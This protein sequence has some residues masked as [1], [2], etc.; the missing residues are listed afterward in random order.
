MTA[1]EKIA[2]RKLSM[3]ELAEEL[4]NISKACK[5]MGYSRS[6]F[7]EIKRAFQL[8]GFEG[9]TDK[10]PIPKS[11]PNK[12]PLSVEKRIIALSKEHPAW[13][14]TRLS[15]ELA[16]ENIHI[17]SATVRN[18]LRRYGLGTKCQRLLK[19][20]QETYDKG[21]TLTIEQIK[22]IEKANPC[23][24]ERHVESY[25]PGYL[26]CQDTFFVGSL[27]GV[28]KIYLQVVVDSFSSY[29]FARL[30]TTHTAVASADMV[31]NWVTPFYEKYDL[32]VEHILT[33]RGS[34]FC[35]RKDAHPYELMLSLLNIEHRK[36]KVASP[37]TNGFVERF[38][39]TLLDEFFREAFRKKLYLSID[40][41]QKDLDVWLYYYNHERSHQGY[42]N[43]GKKPVETFEES[44]RLLLKS[45][46]KSKDMVTV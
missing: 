40:E 5:M 22:A 31:Y 13:G 21:M 46:G 33:D 43:M 14:K 29:G 18:I 19:L 32:K 11:F 41:L 10:M 1:K 26:L 6:Q 2:Q 36:T 45:R 20:E 7:Y 44:K 12:T 30:Y 23:F 27:K 37:K 17:C 28:G 15:N 35:G 8:H 24:K 39:R 16:K 38:N 4:N 3:L 42:R 34:E 9:L 25:Y